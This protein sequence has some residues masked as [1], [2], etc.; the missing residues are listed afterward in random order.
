VNRNFY[1]FS[2][3]F[4]L[5]CV[6][7]MPFLATA[8]DIHYSNFGFSPLNLNP[9]L[10]GVFN[11]D[12]RGTGNYRSQWRGLGGPTTNFSTFSGSFDMKVNSK[13]SPNLPPFRVGAFLRH[14]QAGWSKLTNSSVYLMGS[15]MRALT[16]S[17][18][19]SGGISLGVSQRRFQTGDLTWDDQFVD[20]QF[21]GNIRSADL[22]V[23]DQAV[24]YPDISVGAN[25]HR[26]KPGQRSGLDAGVG[27]FH[28]NHPKISFMGTPAMR[29]EGRLT[30][31]F[32][33][34]IKVANKVDLL[35][36]GMGQFQGQHREV[37]GGVGGR[38]YLVD[39]HTKLIA[40]QA[41]V[42]F[43]NKDAYS[44]NLGL[45]WN[46]WKFAVNFDSNFSPFRVASNRWGGPEFNVIYIFA[47]VKPAGYCPLCPPYL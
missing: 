5:V 34:N 35:L 22:S 23:F 10:T 18:L 27:Y 42:M 40:L 19:L 38:L 28:L 46:N 7:V 3:V 2:K 43:R 12:Y 11:G 1:S 6:L 31:H 44:P 30:L 24:V 8:Q 13:K 17:D 14:D 45:L 26:Q 41:G 16:N 36:D 21:N 32:N 39:K 33:S 25:Y 37:L 4:A 20:R 29:C 15:Y 9:A 47:K